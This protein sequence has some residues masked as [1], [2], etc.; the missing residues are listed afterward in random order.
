MNNNLKV[1]KLFVDNKDKSFTIK[2][3]AEALKM[4]YRIVYEEII[5]LEKE[6]LI[7]ITKHGN[8]KVCEF[9]YKYNSKIVEIE[10]IKKQELFKN[11]NI[12]LVYSRIKETK[13]PFYCLILFG[14]YAN[15]TSQRGSD[16]D[17]CLITDNEKINKK[18]QS[19]LSITPIDIHMQEFTSEH[20]LAMLKSREF[21]VGNEIVKNNI[22]LHGI[23]SFYEMINNVKQ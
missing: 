8:S 12:K 15:K 19:M 2:K 11:K 16:I 6:G 4:N 14:S 18:V 17:L 21:N 10:E 5:K 1:L 20:F 9:N 23:E 3:A 7:K 13:S 22:V